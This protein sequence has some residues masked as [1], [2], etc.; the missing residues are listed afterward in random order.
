MWGPVISGVLL[1]PYGLGLWPNDLIQ[2]CSLVQEWSTKVVIEIALKEGLKIIYGSPK[3][4][5]GGL[6]PSYT[7]ECYLKVAS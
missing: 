4:I 7:P 6:K 5:R 2:G 1:R 3:S